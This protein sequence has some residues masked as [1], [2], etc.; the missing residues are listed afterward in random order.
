[1]VIVR[2][3]DDFVMGLESKADADEMLLALKGRRRLRPDAPRGQDAADRV[4][5]VRGPLPATA[6]QAAARDLCLSGLHPQLWVDPGRPV[7]R[8]AQD[9][10]ETP[11]AQADGVPPS[12]VREIR[13]PGSV[14]AKAEWLSY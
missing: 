12:R 13:P 14:R 1:M 7:D 11:D 5:P 8:E 6:W 2:Y 10:R 9:G 3:P 4:W